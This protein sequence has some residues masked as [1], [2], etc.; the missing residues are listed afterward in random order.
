MR[1]I[2]ARLSIVFPNLIWDPENDERGSGHLVRNCHVAAN[3]EV[4]LLVFKSS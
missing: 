3:A 2:V 4:W 1:E